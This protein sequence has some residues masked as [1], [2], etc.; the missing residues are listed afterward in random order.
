VLVPEDEFARAH[1]ALDD[2]LPGEPVKERYQAGAGADVEHD[3]VLPALETL[4]AELRTR[5]LEQFELPAGGSTELELVQDEPWLAFNYYRGACAAGSSSTP[6]PVALDG[7]AAGR[8]TRAGP[9]SPLR[10]RD[11]GGAPRPRSRAVR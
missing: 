4:T 9:G 6:T 8:G 2:A 3:A 10:A 7:P 1:E 11:K 5:T